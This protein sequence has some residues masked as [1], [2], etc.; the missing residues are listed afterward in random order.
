MRRA[1][2]KSGLY[3]GLRMG[4][5][6]RAPVRRRFAFVLYVATCWMIVATGSGRLL[7]MSASMVSADVG[8]AHT[9]DPR[10]T[11]QLAQLEDQF[12]SVGK[13]AAPS[14]VAISAALTNVD[15]DDA[16]REESLN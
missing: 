6:F 10:G 2:R 8:L 9:P 13:V 12:E 15:T 14:V 1:S 3:V 5:G 7:P 16:V 11:I 4:C